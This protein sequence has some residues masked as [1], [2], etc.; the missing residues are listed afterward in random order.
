[1]SRSTRSSSPGPVAPTAGLVPSSPRRARALLL[2]SLISAALLLAFAPTAL[3]AHHILGPTPIGKPC[4]AE[5][6]S[7]EELETPVAV[8]VNEATGD[9][10]V[11]DQGDATEP[12]GRVVRFSSAGVFQSEFNG[13]GTLPGEEH[14][15]G[16]LGRPEEIESGRF[17]YSGEAARPEHFQTS[18]LAVDNDPASPSFEDVYVVDSQADTETPAMPMVVDKFSPDGEYLGQITTNPE[19]PNPHFGFVFGVSVDSDGQ[20]WLFEQN[21]EA[22]LRGSGVANYTNGVE[23][24]FVGLR[25]TNPPQSEFPASG[26]AVDSGDNLYLHN[27][28]PNAIAKFDSGGTLLKVP[29]GDPEP[30]GVAVEAGTDSVYIDNAN[31]W[32]G[33]RPDGEETESNPVPGEHGAGIAVDASTRTVYVADPSTDVVYV[34]PPEPPGPPTIESTSVSDVTAASARLE[35]MVNPRSEAGEGPTT[36]RFEY[37]LCT[38]GILTCAAS[39]FTAAVPGQIAAGF[40]A[41]PVRATIGGLV[42]GTAYHLRLSA[43][44]SHSTGPSF[45][46]TVTFTTQP[47]NS[48]STLPDGRA[49]ELVSPP[50][51]HGALIQ[52]IEE[53]VIQASASGDA[54][55]Y[56]ANGP[57]EGEPA[58]N[59]QAVQVL[60]RRGGPDSSP[61]VS[62][63]IATPHEAPV[64]ISESGRGEYRFFSE[65]L[66]RAVVQ[67]FGP[68]T[69]S[70]SPQAS[71][72]TAYLRDLSGSCGSSCYRPLVTG[73]PEASRPCP[74]AVQEAANVPPGTE[75]GR[76]G[77]CVEAI[78]GPEFLGA[79]PDATHV[80]L[81]SPI[82]LAAGMPPE[83]ASLYEWSAGSL[84]PISILPDG[85][86]AEVPTALGSTTTIGAAVIA[87]HAVSADGSRVV[88]S[89]RPSR[90]GEH[91]YLR[92]D[93]LDPQSASGECDEAGR[94]CTIQLDEVQGGSGEGTVAPVFQDASADG[95]RIFFTDSQRLVQGASEAG[96]DLY[97]CRV[98]E[99]APGHLSC[100]LTDLTARGGGEAAGVRGLIAGSSSDGSTVYFTANGVLTH[101]PGPRGESAVAGDCAPPPVMEG[102]PEAQ[103][104]PQRCNLYMRRGG[105]IRLV[106]VLSGAD[107]PDFALLGSAGLASLSARVSPDGAYLAFMSRRPLTGYDNRDAASGEPDQ[108][109]F[110]YDSAGVGSLVCASC[111]PSGARPHGVEY[112]KIDA[113][114]GG[115]AGGYHIRPASSWIAASIPGFTPLNGGFGF[116]LHQ[117]RYLSDQGRLFFNSADALVPGDSNGTEDVYQYEPPQ[118]PGAPPGDGCT[119]SSAGYSPVSAGCIDLISSG[120]SKS[121]SAFLD[122]SESGDD[123]FFLTAGRLSRRD[124]DSAFDVYDARVGGGEAETTK[125]VECSGD[126]CQQ[127]AAAPDDATPGSLTFSGPENVKECSKGRQL[128][129]GKCVAKKQKKAK[130][131]KKHHKKKGKKSH[132]KAKSHKKGGHR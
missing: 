90:G 125:A 89:E 118:G 114:E 82:A 94:A 55:S 4:A 15:A 54:I 12:T 17:D 122:A 93:A 42:P 43:E 96:A 44:N 24:A 38:G 128:K 126:A 88:F 8:A 31:A 57:T 127:P 72:R 76:E 2:V 79:S 131:K 49:W 99:P 23:N 52:P 30:V 46:Q 121:E 70:L 21:L 95:S 100:R 7:G 35:G 25:E 34:Y 113:S 119:T 1:M 47:S 71:Q 62:Q 105:Q 9:I 11:L 50:N 53:G 6:C 67:P 16:S 19:F 64:G 29:F 59:S 26:F 98:E 3:A 106:A 51:K 22:G 45:G 73:C 132:K 56:L 80:V 48:A 20:V 18:G 129:K 112:R 117:S 101:E 36:Y 32:H 78:C 111:D 66:E 14:A 27:L 68:F 61:W 10:Y 75:F 115:L 124:E 60:S 83:A 81:R 77:S 37:G 103:L 120:T 86:P 63:D 107:Y 116:A 74:P 65:E 39:P 123:V 108:E 28:A 58:G 85:L 41:E 13:S 102:A 97:E 84:R 110:L 104:A 69:R 40:E 91:L 109:V 33:Y 87:R 130:H 5:P 92:A